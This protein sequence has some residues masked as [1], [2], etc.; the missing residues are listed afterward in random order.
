[1]QILNPFEW[2]GVTTD[3][4]W[5][6]IYLFVIAAAVICTVMLRGIQ[7]R[8]FFTAWRTALSPSEVSKGE[9]GDM[10]PLQA[11]INTLSACL[12]NNSLAGMATALAAGGPGAAVWA[13]IIGMLLMAVRFIEVYASSEYGKHASRKVALGGPMLYLKSVPGGTFWSYIY[14]LFGL[15]FG[16]IAGN[17]LQAN[18]ISY[19]LRKTLTDWGWVSNQYLIAAGLLGFVVYVVLG[20]ADRIVKVSDRIVPVKVIVFFATS[21]AVL[22]THYYKIIPALK[23]MVA[24][25]FTPTAIA[26][27]MLG[28]TVQQAFRYGIERSIMATEAGL[29]TAAILFGFTGSTN[30]RRDALLGMLTTFISTIVCLLVVLCIMVSGVWKIGGLKGIELTIAS[31]NT[32]FGVYGGLI[33]SF[34]S[35]SFGIGVLVTFAYVTRAIWLFLTGGRWEWVSMVLY[36]VFATI[37]AL[38]DVET[39]IGFAAIPN[40]A[41]LLINLSG[42]IYLAPSLARSV[43]GKKSAA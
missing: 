35:I 3:Q 39:L 22:G 8:Q 16:L 14:G 43:Y 36:S 9:Q 4:V 20:G 10:T 34:L 7:V 19:S 28:F 40:A 25:A 5:F 12:G 24:S 37:G 1:M 11:F 32:V 15:A 30:P 33:G 29:G 17:A 31:Y 18:A 38:G 41:L 13:V 27:G 26:G 6:A 23:L 21:F 2:L 42:L